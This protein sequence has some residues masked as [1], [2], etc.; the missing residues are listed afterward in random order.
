MPKA[1]APGAPGA[2]PALLELPPPLAPPSY[3]PFAQLPPVALDEAN[4]R[5][6][7]A[8]QTARTR[9][10]QGRVLWIDATA[11]LDRINTVP[12]IAAL[13]ERIK[14]AGF[15][16]VVLDVKP[17][18]GFTLYPSRHAP[19]LTEWKGRTLPSSF[20]P[21]TP[22]V[23]SAHAH[24]LQ[25]IASMNA[26]SEGHRDFGMGPGYDHP[27]WQTTLYEVQARVRAQTAPGAWFPLTDRAN[28]P[29]RGPHEIAV[30]TDLKR[31]PVAPAATLALL[32]AD[33]RVLAQLDGTALAGTAALWV[34]PEGS[35]ALVGT[36][37]GGDFLRQNARAGEI[38]AIE[39]VPV[40]VPISQR[41]ERQVPLMVNPH[42]PVVVQRLRDMVAELVAGYAVDGVLFDDRFRY[43]GINAD[44]GDDTRRAFEGWIGRALRWPD[45]VL[46]QEIVFPTLARR[47]VPGPHYEAWL[48]WRSLTLRNVL[49]AV[50]HGVKTIRPQATVSVYTGAWY[51]EYPAYGANWAAPDLDA[52]FRFL[53]PGYRQTGFAHLLDWMTIGAYYPSATIAE[54]TAAGRSPGASVEAAGQLAN[55]VVNNQTWMYTGIQLSDYK[56]RPGALKNALQAAAASTQGVMVFDLS[57]DIEPFWPVFEEAFAVPAQAPHAVPGLLAQVRAEHDAGKAAGKRDPP[58]LIYSGIPGTGF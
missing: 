48:L 2:V 38:L 37:A 28:R 52:G 13:A 20:D 14:K 34:L 7:V 47:T 51:G 26:F 58:V 36:G 31:L 45:D 50:V 9:K 55:R 1:F 10:L 22:F 3:Q 46:R 16:T 6:G 57:H 30:Y 15:N 25:L 40:Y 27:E 42:H 54:A 39:S 18:I 33:G 11:N 43:A 41:P 21:L 29:A 23:Q 24:G 49:A 17:I 12:K 35:G 8:Q 53:T 5:I 56:G 4:N 44:F 32:A 19:K